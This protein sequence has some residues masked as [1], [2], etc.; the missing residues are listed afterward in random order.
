[1]ASCWPAFCGSSNESIS[2]ERG[3]WVRAKA[4]LGA[5]A[6]STNASTTPSGITLLLKI[7]IG[8][9]L[10]SCGFCFTPNSSVQPFIYRQFAGQRGASLFSNTCRFVWFFAMRRS[11][12]ITHLFDSLVC[13]SSRGSETHEC[14][15]PT[16]V[17]SPPPTSSTHRG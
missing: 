17:N 14:Q 16:T 3:L 1:M 11:A 13:S 7:D 5:P 4:D 8:F 2:I 15:A 10:Y 6:D 9:L 12:T